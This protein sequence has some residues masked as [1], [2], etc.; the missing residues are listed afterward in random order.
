MRL[1]QGLQMHL[2]DHLR[3]AVADRGHIPSALPLFPNSLRDA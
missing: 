2:D 3:H 1:H